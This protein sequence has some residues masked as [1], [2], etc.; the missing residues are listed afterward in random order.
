M[1]SPWQTLK[2]ADA[3]REYLA[4]LSYLPLK[5]YWAI[6]AFL[7]FTF[8]IQKQLRG[9]PGISGYSLRAKPMSRQFWTLS[10][11]DSETALM[12]FITKVPHSQAMKALLPHMGPT[13][14]T[15]W[16][17]P[18]SALPVKWEEAMQLSKKGES[19]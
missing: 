8:Q 17:V 19:S 7:R 13:N 15:R 6:P 16:K 11:W 3:D 14:F 4:L 10:A 12:D 5:T 9:T 2:P 1:D 18:G